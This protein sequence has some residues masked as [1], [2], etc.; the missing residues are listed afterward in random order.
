MDRIS[1]RAPSSN[2]GIGDAH[3]TAIAGG[4]AKLLAD[5]HTLQLTTHH[6][7]WNVTGQCSTRCTRCSCR[8]TQNSGVLSIRS[9]SVGLSACMDHKMQGIR[10]GPSG[11]RARIARRAALVESADQFAFAAPRAA[12]RSSF[13]RPASPIPD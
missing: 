9:L 2:I 11:P 5:T 1:A 3:R 7:H 4:L 6:F 13:L 8:S 12:R 10:K